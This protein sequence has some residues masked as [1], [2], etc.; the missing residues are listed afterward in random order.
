MPDLTPP[1]PL[2]RRLGHTPLLDILRGRITG[3]LDWQS[4]I[5]EALLPSEVAKHIQTIVERLPVKPLQ[6]VMATE[7]LIRQARAMLEEGTTPQGVVILIGKP[8][9]VR[10]QLLE[11]VIGKPRQLMMKTIK[12]ALILFLIGVGI[13]STM[14]GLMMMFS[15]TKVTMNHLDNFNRAVLHL[16][17]AD[18]A[19]PLYRDA[20]LAA[21][22]DRESLIDP[23]ISR[24]T[25]LDEQWPDAQAYLQEHQDMLAA[26]REAA[27]KPGLGL[28]IP[29]YGFFEGE[30]AFVFINQRKGLLS[31]ITGDNE[32]DGKWVV[33]QAMM[34][35]SEGGHAPIML[36]RT[37]GH[38]FMLDMH[39]ALR[40]GDMARFM[41]NARC[42]EGIARQ[43][44]GYRSYWGSLFAISILAGRENI[45]AEALASTPSVFSDE[46]LATLAEWFSDTQ[47]IQRLDHTKDEWEFL[48]LL[49]RNYT[50]RGWLAADGITVSTI[51]NQTE[52][53]WLIKIK[54]MPLLNLFSPSRDQLE[55]EY[56]ALQRHRE[57]TYIKPL[58]ELLKDPEVQER[59]S[60]RSRST[61]GSNDE[62]SRFKQIQLLI[63]TQHTDWDT[64]S[65]HIPA[66]AR[67]RYD[68]L[69]VAI[70]LEQFRRATGTYPAKL[71]ELVPA[72]LHEMPMDH[73]TGQ[74]LL[75]RLSEGKPI[76]YGRGLDGDDDQMDLANRRDDDKIPVQ[77][78]WIVY[79]PR[80]DDGL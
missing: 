7:H 52:Q 54:G 3:R 17:Q 20:I 45:I 25:P 18:R 62:T 46:Q 43:I 35:L 26:F 39:D 13:H 60:S 14:G 70:T 68:A 15:R 65:I 37:I 48:D 38:I 24:L 71:E 31:E 78:D 16:P 21:G 73:S 67:S 77:G 55:E 29:P 19:W 40:K 69:L 50:P 72:Y 5:D 47:M 2:M 66:M 12:Y 59:V 27:Q 1:R 76:L 23:S 58:W 56:A 9:V 42:M 36:L 79:P 41:D 30:D 53:P 51:A 64:Y 6:C 10:Q 61:H 44:Q 33:Q 75:Y 49:Q 22:H 34:N 74:P 63:Y 80:L 32:T 8:A 4:L 57:A 28:E 11:D